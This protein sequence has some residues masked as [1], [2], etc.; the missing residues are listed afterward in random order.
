MNNQLEG[1]VAIITGGTSGIGAATAELFVEHGARVVIAGRS[2]QRGSDLAARIGE[3]ALYR[4]VDVGHSDEIEALVNG[5][6]ADFGRIDC[7]FNNAGLLGSGGGIGELTADDFEQTVNVN[8]RSV[9]L[10]MK[11]AAPI[12]RSQ[13]SGSIINNASIAAYR[14]GYGTH[15]YSMAK[16][17]VIHLTRSVAIEMGEHHVRVN[18]ISPGFIAT[19]MMLGDQPPDATVSAD[20]MSRLED[21]LAVSTPIPRSGYPADIAHAALYLAS[22]HSSF[23]NGL[24]LVVDGGA[25][26]GQ[27]WSDASP[28]L[29][30]KESPG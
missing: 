10:G 6:Y 8:L 21:H 25:I 12:M 19:P 13:A 23:V 1:K 30:Q 18:S 15:L 27:R 4:A 22:D 11:Y 26:R 28:V 16:A 3:G 17:A 9:F 20:A 29:T 5:V 14:F 24:D 2:Q 7:L